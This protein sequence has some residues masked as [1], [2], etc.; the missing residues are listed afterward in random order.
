VTAAAGA[1]RW[2]AQL[3]W[4]SRSEW[5]ASRRTA[6]GD[7]IDEIMSAV[8]TDPADYASAAELDRA[9][10]E[11]R[12]VG[13]DLGAE[14]RQPNAAAL[15]VFSLHWHRARRKASIATIWRLLDRLTAEDRAVVDHAK[16]VKADRAMANRAA[17]ELAAGSRGLLRLL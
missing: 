11:L 13:R 4:S 2:P 14:L 6:Y 10:A 5:E 12:S 17:D 16:K 9:G 7:D 1:D 8:S 15:S 3:R